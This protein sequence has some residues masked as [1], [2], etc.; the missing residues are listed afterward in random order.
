MAAGHAVRA[1]SRDAGRLAEIEA[2]GAEPVQADPL[3]LATLVPQHLANTSAVCWLFG[4]AAGDGAEDLHRTRLQTVLE[5]LVD[6]PARGF[7][8]EAAGSVDP[9]LLREGASAVREAHLRWHMPVEVVEED[10]VDVQRWTSA[11]ADAVERLL[12][13]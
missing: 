12:S 6:S 1:T 2:L 3:R 4:S 5:R 7:V 10:P 13:A 9:E 11:M 8:Y